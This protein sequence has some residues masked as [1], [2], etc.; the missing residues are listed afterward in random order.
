MQGEDKVGSFCSL[1]LLPI[2]DLIE[3]GSILKP[4][5]DLLPSGCLFL[6]QEQTHEWRST[7]QRKFEL[8]H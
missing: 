4:T 7:R 8:G 2:V 6:A 1:A 5:L 3:N